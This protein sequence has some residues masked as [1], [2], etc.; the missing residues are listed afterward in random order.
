MTDPIELEFS[1]KYTLDHSEHYAKKHHASLLRRISNWREQAIGRN[2]LKMAGDPNVVLDLPCGAGR[3][4]PILAE[5]T[6]RTI[7]AADYSSD[8]VE[9]ARRVCDPNIVARVQA[10]QSSAFDIQLPDESVDCIFC[11][12]L[13][14]HIGDPEHRAIMLKE[15]HRVTRDTVCISLWVD[16]NRQATRRLRLEQVQKKDLKQKVRNRFVIPR[17]RIESE[18]ENSGFCIVGH[19]DILKYFS[20]WRIYVLKKK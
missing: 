4:W 15:F 11:M 7:Y 17:R 8:M 1:K 5:K 9:V 2:S 10:F 12:R 19:Y 6:D 14:H 13:L 16:G 20:M 18:F 3:F